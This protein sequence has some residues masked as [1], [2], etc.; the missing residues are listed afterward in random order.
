MDA[1][2]RLEASMKVL[3]KRIEVMRK[4]NEL[5][6]L[7]NEILR[8]ENEMSDM[9]I[10]TEIGVKHKDEEETLASRPRRHLPKIPEVG[11]RF[12]IDPP[13]LNRFDE[14][15]IGGALASANPP[16]QLGSLTADSVVQP[17]TSTPN[18]ERTKAP[19]AA[20]VKPATFDSMGHWSDYKAHFNACAE[21]NG[22]TEKEKGLYLAVSLRGQAQGVFG[23]LSTKSCNYDELAKALKERFAPP[24]QTELYR[25]Q[26]KERRQKAA[27]TLTELGQ[28]IW[29]LTNLAYAT[30]PVDVRETLAKEQF[31]DCLHSSDMRLR[32]KQARP[33][34]LNDAVRHAV[35]LEAFN[36]A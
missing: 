1:T 6:L 15:C 22:W 12:K 32:I 28:D 30:A 11:A 27:E 4:K 2:P 24:N 34:S 25:V 9:E 13:E 31:I 23:N 5:S 3:G 21:I 8:L 17:V 20:K 19:M 16:P 36:K 14:S 29:R 18:I 7:Q 26:L 33:K 35:E 10:G